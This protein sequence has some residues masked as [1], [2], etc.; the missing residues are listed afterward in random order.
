MTAYP[1]DRRAEDLPEGMAHADFT[2]GCEFTCGGKRWRCTDVGTRVI[3]S[4][5]LE[6]RMMVRSWADVAEQR[7]ERFISNE[8]QDLDGAP[9][10]V[11]EHIFD[12]YDFGGC[13][14]LPAS[15]PD[16]PDKKEDET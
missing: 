10:G 13:M 12:E 11:A 7:H 6:P 8:P 16:E 2:I 9:Y 3:V 15:R 5:C 1:D 14:P 4:I